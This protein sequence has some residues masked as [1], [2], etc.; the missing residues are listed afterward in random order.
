ME[1]IHPFLLTLGLSADADASAIRRAYARQ[2][3]L[4]D[5][6]SQAVQFQELREAYEA[7]LNWVGGNTET[8]VGNSAVGVK[9][10]DAAQEAAAAQVYEQFLAAC[11]PLRQ[12]DGLRD[13]CA[14]EQTL[15][16]HLADGRLL[17]LSASLMFE[18]KIATFLAL[19]WKPGN[20]M[21]FRVAASVF[22][23][24]FDSRRVQ[25]LGAAADVIG[26][27]LEQGYL[28]EC[29][30]E[31]AYKA[32]RNVM[33][34]LRLSGPPLTMRLKA[35]MPHLE[36]MLEHFPDLIHV[37]AGMENV[38][39]WRALHARLPASSSAVPVPTISFGSHRA[40]SQSREVVRGLSVPL[41]IVLV[42]LALFR[43]YHFLNPV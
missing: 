35:E 6:A 26:K 12:K 38:E 24:E 34:G 15:L 25:Q 2:L 36:A 9:A 33:V 18:V 42:A 5:L 40:V 31:A 29:Q 8:K 3:K 19:G 20:D 32:S 37:T 22:E 39:R 1:Q 13:Q 17:D 4:L 7:A 43:V 41:T 28:F 21:L 14:W 30:D 27:T 11:M 16:R 10:E 23:W